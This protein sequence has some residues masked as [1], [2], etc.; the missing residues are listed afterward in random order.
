MDGQTVHTALQ[1]MAKGH[2][3]VHIAGSLVKSVP[4][5]FSTPELALAEVVNF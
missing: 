2:A 1:E 5:K 4:Q 3:L